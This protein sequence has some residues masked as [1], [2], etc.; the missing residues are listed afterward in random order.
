MVNLHTVILFHIKRNELKSY[1][2]ERN[3]KYLLLG[4]R[5]DVKATCCMSPSIQDSV[6]GKIPL[7]KD[8]LRLPE[9]WVRVDI[10]E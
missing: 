5:I 8:A 10:A 4:K 2:I 3:L 7:R 9:V 6:K 1:K